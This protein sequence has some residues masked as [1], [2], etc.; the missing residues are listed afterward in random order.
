MVAP[1][2]EQE[3]KS[4]SQETIKEGQSR[5]A[6]IVEFLDLMSR[7]PDERPTWTEIEGLSEF[8]KILWIMWSEFK[9]IDGHL[10][11][12]S[13]NRLLQEQEIRLVVPVTLRNNLLQL[14]HGGITEG[15]AGISRTK[16]QV[17]RRAYWPGWSW[18]VK[19][20]V[21]ACEP[22]ARF[23]W[24]KGPKQGHLYPM[25]ASYPFE[26]I[27]IDVMGPHPRS[28]NGFVFILTVIDYYSKFSFAFPMRNQEAATVAKLLIDNVICLVVTPARI[29]SDQGPNFESTLFKELCRV[30]GI[31]RIWTSPYEAST[32]GMVERF[33]FTLNYI[34]AK[35]IKKSQ[36]DWDLQVQPA[37]A[38][39]RATC[40]SATLLTP[41]FII[42]VRENVM[43]ADLALCNPGA[44]P[45]KWEQR[46][47]VRDQT[48]GTIPDD[49][50]NR[51]EPTEVCRT[52]KEV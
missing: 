12:D 15:H 13:I 52:K 30:L 19:L 31:A 21:K 5:D 23:Q 1:V 26:T 40:H 42:F 3:P 2:K 49:V 6:E 36:R 7:I 33:Q 9:V 39:Y 4:W 35:N 32:N 11:R 50:R 17:R 44:I 29:L 20:F 46:P 51:K 22:C 10:Y 27:S 47:G 43:P 24:G 45:E 38:A 16:N 48:A 25:V 14:V 28:A 37:V 18:S 41:N 34:L 8:T